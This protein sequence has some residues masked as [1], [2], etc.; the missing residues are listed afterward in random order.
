VRIGFFVWVAALVL[1]TVVPVARAQEDPAGTPAYLLRLERMYVEDSVCVLVRSDGQY[2]LERTDWDKT[3]VFEGDLS[4]SEL[5]RLEHWVGENELFDLTQEKIVA[6]IFTGPKDQLSLGVNRPGYWQNLNFPAPSNWQRYRQSVVPLVQW[7]DELRK[8]KH[9]VKLREEQG[10]TNCKPPFR[11]VLSTRSAQKKSET[12]KP[13]VFFVQTTSFKGKQGEK[14]CAVV[15]PDGRYHRETKSQHNGSDEVATAVYEG[16]VKADSMRELGAI[17]TS[18]ELRNRREPQLPWGMFQTDGEITG[19]TFAQEG[20]ARTTFFWKYAPI[21]G[22]VGAGRVE[23][24]GMQTLEPLR[25]WLKANVE[26][27]GIAPAANLPLSDCVPPR[28]P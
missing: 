24:S 14:R 28:V 27:A 26:D 20:R 13:F 6:P 21:P 1:G 2:H 10:R 17:L 16:S 5:H 12:V 22:L 19:L 8:S 9:R 3:E 18:P 11:P 15:Y 25:E 4:D 7:L 23:E